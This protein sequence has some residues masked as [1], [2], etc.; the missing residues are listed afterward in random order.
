MQFRRCSGFFKPKDV[1]RICWSALC[2]RVTLP[3]CLHGVLGLLATAR[4]RNSFH[5]R[6]WKPFSDGTTEVCRSK[7][8]HFL[9]FRF[10]CSGSPSL[11][12]KE[13]NLWHQARPHCQWCWVAEIVKIVQR[14]EVRVDT[15][16]WQEAGHAQSEMWKWLTGLTVVQVGNRED[17]IRICHEVSKIH[18]HILTCKVFTCM[19]NFDLT[20]SNL[21]DYSCFRPEA[22][23][24]NIKTPL[25][26]HDVYFGWV[27][28]DLGQWNGGDL[29]TQSTV[30]L[31]AGFVHWNLWLCRSG[32]S[33]VGLKIVATWQFHGWINTCHPKLSSCH[34]LCHW[35]I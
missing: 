23:H 5:I 8:W 2:W 20:Y 11:L 14:F 28:P 9:D 3:A 24:Q 22:V 21:A 4:K 26:K 25:N 13:Q 35:I 16:V 17:Q 29:T 15:C 18:G 19:D 34:D 32:G 10:D 7:P 31:K 1:P 6:S 33:Q 12:F 27:Q 30:L